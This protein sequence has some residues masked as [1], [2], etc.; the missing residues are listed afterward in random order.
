MSLISRQDGQDISSTVYTIQTVNFP[1]S[2]NCA[3]W[4]HTN[5]ITPRFANLRFAHLQDLL[6]R[7]QYHLDFTTSDSRC[8]SNHRCRHIPLESKL[9][10]DGNESWFAQASLGVVNFT[11]LHPAYLCIYLVYLFIVSRLTEMQNCI[12]SSWLVSHEQTFLSKIPSEST[13]WSNCQ[14]H[15]SYSPQVIKVTHA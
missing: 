13:S 11:S 7:R 14:S 10:W 6:T 15:S 8:L 4:E 1:T 3:T 5:I 2:R 9:F 12:L